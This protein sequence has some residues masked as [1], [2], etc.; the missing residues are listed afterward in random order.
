M[1]YSKSEIEEI[2]ITGRQHGRL[3]RVPVH[4]AGVRLHCKAVAED[5]SNAAQI[6][7]HDA[8]LR[9]CDGGQNLPPMVGIGLRYLKI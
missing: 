4:E 8:S 3:G 1:G 2:H 6:G 5:R 9:R 7:A